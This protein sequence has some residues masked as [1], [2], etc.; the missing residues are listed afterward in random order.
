[1]PENLTE[2]ELE[3]LLSLFS[4][5]ENAEQLVELL[6]PYVLAKAGD[7]LRERHVNWIQRKTRDEIWRHGH[8]G[9]I[10][11]DSDGRE[12]YD[13]TPLL[14]NGIADEAITFEKL[15]EST[16][17]QLA[18]YIQTYNY[19]RYTV[20]FLDPLY[21]GVPLKNGM[22]VNVGTLANGLLITKNDGRPAHNLVPASAILKIERPFPLDT[23]EADEELGQVLGYEPFAVAARLTPYED[24]VMMVPYAHSM[25]FLNEQ[26]EVSRAPGSVIDP[27]Q[28]DAG[29]VFAG[30]PELPANFV[31]YDPKD[32]VQYLTGS[33]SHQWEPIP[34]TGT[35]ERIGIGL[36]YNWYNERNYSYI[37][38]VEQNQFIKGH[39]SPG[40]TSLTRTIRTTTFYTGSVSGD[41]VGTAVYDIDAQEQILPLDFTPHAITSP[42]VEVSFRPARNGYVVQ[43][44]NDQR[45]WNQ[46]MTIPVDSHTGF[47]FFTTDRI[48]VDDFQA[49]YPHFA[50]LLFPAS[51]AN[52]FDNYRGRRMLAR[53]ELL[54][55]LNELTQPTVSSQ[56]GWEQQIWFWLTPT[57]A[58]YPYVYV[59][60]GLL[61]SNGFPGIG[62]GLLWQ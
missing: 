27:E 13:G 26:F 1:M 39:A 42:R 34:S 28:L 49:T 46:T 37:L 44:A 9:E 57:P 43:W 7:L 53:L 32:D 60:Q 12:R 58:F 54:S 23:H 8:T 61:S 31:V 3:H 4:D 59:Y 52:V 17:H 35:I 25:T 55:D 48:I 20:Q 15:A 45:S 30:L 38:Y 51:H 40:S 22:T 5:Y 11:T 24:G 47:G 33:F 18:E 6:K 56:L 21:E 14:T 41:R 50:E 62:A 16:L 36:V 2:Q 19:P 10:V 29:S